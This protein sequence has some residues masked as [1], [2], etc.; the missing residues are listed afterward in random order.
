MT[1]IGRVL[2][3]DYVNLLSDL[4]DGPT[5]LTLV[6][7]QITTMSTYSVEWMVLHDYHWS[8]F[9]SRLCQLTQWSSGWSYMANIGRVPNHDYVNLLSGLVDGST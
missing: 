4:V 7:F 8:C 2:S 5:W 1:N 3:H 6:V 9:K